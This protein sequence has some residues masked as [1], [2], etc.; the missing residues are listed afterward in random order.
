MSWVGRAEVIISDTERTVLKIAVKN[1]RETGWR[2]ELI[3]ASRPLYQ[4]MLDA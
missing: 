4:T 2:S 3:F 1:T